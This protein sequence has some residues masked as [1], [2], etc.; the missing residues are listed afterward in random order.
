M[1]KHIFHTLLFVGTLLLAT[2]CH[3]VNWTE[4][5]K[6]MNVTL[7]LPQAGKQVVNLT[8]TN[9]TYTFSIAK[10]YPILKTDATLAVMS[11]EELG[12]EYVSLAE[13]QYVIENPVISFTDTEREHKVSIKFQNVTNLEP[14]VTYALGL[15]LQS[16]NE[17]VEVD[18]ANSTLIVTLRLGEAGTIANPH[19]LHSLD[20][21]KA[22]KDKLVEGQMNYFRMTADIDMQNEEWTTLNYYRKYWINFNGD[23]HI[24]KNLKCSG[25]AASF[26]GVLNDGVCENVVFEN[27]TIEGDNTPIGVVAGVVQRGVVRNVHVSGTITQTGGVNNWDSGKAGGICGTLEEAKAQITECSANV[28]IKGDFVVGGLVGEATRATLTNRCYVSGEILSTQGFAGGIIGNMYQTTVSDCYS[29]G[30]I[31]V[32]ERAGAAGGI[33]GRIDRGAEI[34]NCYSTTAIEAN[35]NAGGIVGATAW[36]TNPK[37]NVIIGCVAWNDSITATDMNS[38]RI[39]GFMNGSSVW[40]NS[41]YAKVSLKVIIPGGAPQT[42]PYWMDTEELNTTERAKVYNGINSTSLIEVTR[43]TINWNSYVW[44]FDGER[45]LLK[46]EKKN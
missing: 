44:D 2:S 10:N 4:G 38:S 37:D 25:G 41:C 45:P 12:S 23:N 19:R 34:Y 27:A 1:R 24:I 16:S 40:G 13:G 5:L 43:K 17:E 7:S 6:P 28:N 29:T 20:D 26:F 31:A 21:L 9:P 46:W 22:M 14:T 42:D 39:A 33:A 3:E 30:K 32:T 15:K 35:G 18:G 8:E 36:G 11:Q